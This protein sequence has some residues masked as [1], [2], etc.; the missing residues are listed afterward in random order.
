MLHFIQSP[1]ICLVTLLTITIR[2]AISIDIKAVSPYANK[3]YVYM[4]NIA[5]PLRIKLLNDS[6]NDVHKQTLPVIFGEGSEERL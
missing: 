2:P 4:S 6:V 1:C 5:S 3:V